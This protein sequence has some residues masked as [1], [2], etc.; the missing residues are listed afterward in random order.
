MSVGLPVFNYF[1]H[2][3][4]CLECCANEN[5]YLDEDDK[6][7]FNAT[8]FSTGKC[9]NLADDGRCTIHDVRPVE[10]R[11]Y[12][13]DV[14]RI[15]GVLTWLVWESCPASGHMPQGFVEREVQKHE[16]ALSKTWI[17]SYVAH[18]EKNEPAKYAS[19]KARVIRP[20]TM[21]E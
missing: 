18:H 9:Q 8:M 4:P 12:P 16:A 20:V 14:K 11:L 6:L 13:L 17:E 21:T 19:M 3:Q 5:L 1:T 2:C 10:C 7:R 15:D